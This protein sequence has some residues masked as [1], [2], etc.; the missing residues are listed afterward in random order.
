MYIC[1]NDGFQQINKIRRERDN[2][3]GV[4]HAGACGTVTMLHGFLT[5]SPKTT[6]SIC[7]AKVVFV[8]LSCYTVSVLEANV[9]FAPSRVANAK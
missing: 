8:Y 5:L 3:E 9:L 7:P 1:R 6:R 2:C 4:S